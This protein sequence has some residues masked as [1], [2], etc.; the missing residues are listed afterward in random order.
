MRHYYE[1]KGCEAMSYQRQGIGNR[2]VSHY[3]HPLR[4]PS[5][6]VRTRSVTQGSELPGAYSNYT[7]FSG[8]PGLGGGSSLPVQAPAAVPEP[9]SGGGLASLFGGGSGS[10]LGT[11]SGFNL[12]QLKNIVDRLG[13]I[14]GIMDTFGKIQKMVESLNQ[15]SPM[16]KLLMGAFKKKKSNDT[17]SGRVKPRRRRRRNRRDRRQRNR[18]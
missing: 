15:M 18:R 2:G 7:G 6:P 8:Y 3:A 16:I 1:Q 5:Y 11:G 10:A 4:R 14:E 12:G 17:S 9:S 13:G